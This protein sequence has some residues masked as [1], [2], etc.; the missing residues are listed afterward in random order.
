MAPFLGLQVVHV[1]GV[2]QYELYN[3]S[4]WHFVV[5]QKMPHVFQ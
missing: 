5:G 2:S 3:G 1:V 4:T